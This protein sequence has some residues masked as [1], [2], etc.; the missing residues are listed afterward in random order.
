MKSKT[1]RLR[2]HLV[3]NHFI[4]DVTSVQH[5]S[6]IYHSKLAE[7]G[8]DV[9]KTNMSFF[10]CISD[11]FSEKILISVRREDRFVNQG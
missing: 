7:T 10:Q 3:L 1:L 2:L 4:H 6:G 8:F 5:V 9:A 11:Y